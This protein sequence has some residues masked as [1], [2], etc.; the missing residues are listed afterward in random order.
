MSQ[1]NV[2][3]Q[4]R[5]R[6]YVFRK[7]VVHKVSDRIRT[8]LRVCTKDAFADQLLLLAPEGADV[9][10]DVGANIGVVTQLYARRFPRARIYALEA[11]PS[12]FATLSQNFVGHERIRTFRCAVSDRDG[13]I[14]FNVNYNSGTSS[15]LEPS[16][17]NRA[18]WASQGSQATIG[19]PSLTIDSFCRQQHIDTIDVLKLDIEGSELP[20]LRGAVPLLQRSAI[21]LVFT[22]VCLTPLYRDQPLLHDLTAFLAGHGYLLYNLYRIVESPIRQ[23]LISNAIFLSPAFRDQL[24]ERFGTQACGW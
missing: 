13:E 3:A 8:A 22:E 11:S 12:T 18:T 20:A 21:K 1:R 7:D 4:S 15:V 14:L 17:F 9:I 6:R 5:L 2:V 24:L 10:L 19:V 16:D 23:G